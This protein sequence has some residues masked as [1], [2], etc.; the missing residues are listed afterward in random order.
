VL[1]HRKIDTYTDHHPVFKKSRDRLMGNYHKYAGVVTDMYY[2]HFLANKFSEYSEEDIY[3][4][5]SKTYRYLLKNFLIL[6]ARMKRI[7]PF[8]MRTNW[9]ASYAKLD[10]LQR[11]FEGLSIR[12][13][14]NSGMENA[15]SDLKANYSLFENEFQE[16]FPE[17]IKYAEETRKNL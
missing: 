12:T 3:Y 10:F 16:F 7:L 11:S 9:L 14:F 8:M 4:F 5:T 1:L 15:V 17:V 2:D 13:P 6:P